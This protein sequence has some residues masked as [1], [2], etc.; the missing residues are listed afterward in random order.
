MS[1]AEPDADTPAAPT[2]GPPTEAAPQLSAAAGG[3]GRRESR[4]LRGRLLD[5]ER[6]TSRISDALLALLLASLLAYYIDFKIRKQDTV[7]VQLSQEIEP[8]SGLEGEWEITQSIENVEFP[9]SGPTE[10]LARLKQRDLSYQFPLQK[11]EVERAL[12]EE[13]G[14]LRH[15]FSLANVIGMPE[16]VSLTKD[17]VP[18]PPVVELQVTPVQTVLLG[19]VEVVEPERFEVEEG[20]DVVVP[21][22]ESLVEVK[23]L[24]LRE[25]ANPTACTLRAH[26]SQYPGQLLSSTRELTLSAF[27]RLTVQ[28][29]GREYE[30]KVLDATAAIRVDVLPRLEPVE[31]Q[32]PLVIPYPEGITAR[33]QPSKVVKVTFLVPAH[34]KAE[35]TEELREAAVSGERHPLN[36]YVIFPRRQLESD[37]YQLVKELP[38]DPQG[39]LQVEV[40]ILP[41]GVLYDSI[42]SGV[43]L[44]LERQQ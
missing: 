23:I 14:R 39:A 42:D 43:Y 29:G 32:V 33:V 2:S 16:G 12:R 38:D 34:R 6:R 8:P 11:E 37:L 4:R 28:T 17:D 25:P 13:Q 27:H 18:T 30:A 20:Y 1:S 10:T 3:A 26:A 7:V 15:Q 5:E 21:P 35:L 31:V 19:N 44:D 36:A 22:A 41:E 40:L 24:G 9:V